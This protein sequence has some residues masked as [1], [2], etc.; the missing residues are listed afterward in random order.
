MIRRGT[1]IF[2]LVT[3]IAIGF[4][5]GVGVSSPHQSASAKRTSKTIQTLEGAIKRNAT[6]IANLK[7]QFRLLSGKTAK[8]GGRVRGNRRA[9]STIATKSGI[10]IEFRDD[11]Y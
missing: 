1:G 5:V 4:T 11:P 2:V 10:R 6:D 7:R 9:T 3:G 8:L